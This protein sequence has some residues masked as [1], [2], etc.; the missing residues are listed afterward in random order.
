MDT[1]TETSRGKEIWRDEG[2]VGYPQAK[3][4]CPE[5]IPPL[6]PSEEISHANTLPETSSF[7]NCE[8]RHFYCLSHPVLKVVLYHRS[9]NKLT[10][11]PLSKES[12]LIPGIQLP[13]GLPSFSVHQVSVSL[14]LAILFPFLIS[15]SGDG[16]GTISLGLQ[17]LWFPVSG[18]W[19]Q[20]LP[21]PW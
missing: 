19:I 10:H 20:D 12:L 11:R 16:T 21:H 14:L 18:L 9:P 4:S 13:Q 8:T 5:Q 15:L 7:Q 1:E 2:K 17:T 3:E 6:Q